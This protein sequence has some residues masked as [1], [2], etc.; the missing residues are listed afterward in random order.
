MADIKKIP[1]RSEIP[2]EHTWNTADIYPTDEAWEKEFDETQAL[3]RTLPGYAGRLGESA[4]TLYEYLTLSMRVGDQL[5]NLY[6][7]ASLRQDEDTRVAK[8]QAMAG[9]AMSLYVEVS[10]ATAFETPELLK[11]PQEALERFYRTGY[12]DAAGIGGFL[13]ST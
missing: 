12:A 6:R 1:Q 10:S 7:Y 4:K 9:K 2:V 8:Y 13:A 3:A 11:L 5:T